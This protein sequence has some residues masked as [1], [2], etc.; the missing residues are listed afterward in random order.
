MSCRFTTY[1]HHRH[2]IVI[3]RPH[4]LPHGSG[5]SP[6]GQIWRSGV[7]QAGS[8]WPGLPPPAN[9]PLVGPVAGGCALN[10]APP[11][12]AASGGAG[13][14]VRGSLPGPKVHQ[15]PPFGPS[16]NTSTHFFSPGERASSVG[17][18]RWS[19]QMGSL[20]KVRQPLPNDF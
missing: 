15:G 10:S 6:G 13:K 1:N 2:P 18:S 7:G 5:G 14:G 11:M 9:H 3:P 8:V 17:L 4:N 16:R 20:R 19:T 12:A